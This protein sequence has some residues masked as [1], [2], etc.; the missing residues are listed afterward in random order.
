MHKQAYISDLI[1]VSYHRLSKIQLRRIMTINV[2]SSH[3]LQCIKLFDD[4]V[5]ITETLLHEFLIT[6]FVFML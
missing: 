1:S 6:R 5:H 3:P 2:W 4:E